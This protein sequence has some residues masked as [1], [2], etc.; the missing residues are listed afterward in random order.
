MRRRRQ[1][2]EQTMPAKLARPT[3]V[4]PRK[5]NPGQELRA[6]VTTCWRARVQAGL[7]D[8]VGG[9]RNSATALS[10]GAIEGWTSDTISGATSRD[11]EGPAP[12]FADSRAEW[13]GRFSVNGRVVSCGALE[14]SAKSV[15]D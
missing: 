15:S 13:P 11:P 2:H 12:W 9:A 7:G 4:Q 1:V 14:S 3:A 6:E 5:T 8:R 10:D